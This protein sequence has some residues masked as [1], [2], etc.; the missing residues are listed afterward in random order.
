MGR[1]ISRDAWAEM[2]RI[3]GRATSAD[4]RRSTPLLSYQA[5]ISDRCRTHSVVFVEKSRRTGAT[6]GAAADAVL[7]SGSA[8]DAGGMDTLYMGTSA[9]MAREFVDAAAD[10]ARRLGQTIRSQGE[11]LFDD[12]SEKGIKATRIDFASGFSIVALPSTPRGLR[13]RQGFVIIDEAAF[14]DDLREVLKAAIALTMLG[15]T[16]PGHLYAQ[17]RGQPVRRDDQRH[18]GRPAALRPGAL[19]PGRGAVRRPVRAH[20]PGLERPPGVV[21]GGRGRLAREP[22]QDVRRR[23]GRGAVRRPEPGRRCGPFRG[24]SS[25]PAPAP[26]CRWCASRTR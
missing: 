25:R 12:G 21:A 6:F 11:A 5:E 4:W 14:V 19:R 15:R 13:G 3:S 17:R 18:P 2:R 24:C 20:L 26:R 7:R 23:R 22:D 10:W 1:E 8:R 16:R 9:D